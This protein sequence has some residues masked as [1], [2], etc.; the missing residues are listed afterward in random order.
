ME[1]PATRLH[2]LSW[3]VRCAEPKGMA[4][5]AFTA[6]LWAGRPPPHHSPPALR[7]HPPHPPVFHEAPELR[8]S[9]SSPPGSEWDSPAALPRLC[10]WSVPSRTQGG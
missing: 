4:P 7:A 6:L 1:P 8:A 3:A 2:H 9:S 10:A 5:S